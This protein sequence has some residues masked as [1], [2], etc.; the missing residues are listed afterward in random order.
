MRSILEQTSCVWNISLTE[1]NVADLLRVQKAAVRM[2]M[3]RNYM[4]YTNA[5]IALKI[6]QLSQKKTLEKNLHEKM[7][8]KKTYLY[9]FLSI[10]T[11]IRR[12]ENYMVVSKYINTMKI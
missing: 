2:I 12:T 7:Q 9:L 6:P 3:K 1:E 4:D 10:K 8:K 5:L 11:H